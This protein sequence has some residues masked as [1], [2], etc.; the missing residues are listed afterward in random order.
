MLE[1]V[2]HVGEMRSLLQESSLAERKAFIRTSVEEIVVTGKEAVL[3]YIPPLPPGSVLG[4][5]GNTVVALPG[6]VLSSVR[7]GGP[8]EIR[9]SKQFKAGGTLV[10]GL[11]RRARAR[12]GSVRLN[13]NVAEPSYRPPGMLGYRFM[14][15]MM[16]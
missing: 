4:P 7:S 11:V 8:T 16:P 9:T 6:Q 10:E 1:V 13:L 5:G 15:P 3:R 2:K 14:R 12:S